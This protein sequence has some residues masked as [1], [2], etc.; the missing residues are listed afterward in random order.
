MLKMAKVF[1]TAAIAAGVTLG[2]G[3]LTRPVVSENPTTKTSFQAQVKQQSIDKVDL[4]FAIDN[5]ASMGD[6]QDLL[7]AAVPILVD[8]LLNPN[9]VATATTGP[10]STC[11]TAADCTSLGA[12]AQC[13]VTGNSGQGQCFL[14]GDNSACSTFPNTKVEFDAVHDMH[15]GIVSSSLGGAVPDTGTCNPTASNDPTHQNDQGHLLNRT[16]NGTTEGTVPNAAPTDNNGGNFLAWLPSANPKNA[17][18]PLPNVTPYTNGDSAPFVAD[19][20]SLVE[21]VQQHG[22]GLEAQLESWYRFLIQ[23]DPYNTIDFTTGG[24]PQ[25]SLD[26]VDATLLKMRHDFLR[27]D[28]L[29]AIIQL[30]DEE[31]SWSDPLWLSSSPSTVSGGYGWTSRDGNFPGGP[32]GGIGAGP[33]GTSDCDQPVNVNTT[34]PSGG[35][36]DPNC[37]SCAFPQSN[38][39]NGQSIGSDANC[40]SCAPGDTNCPVKGWYTPAAPGVAFT[41]A[42]GLNVRYGY[43]YSRQRY[44]LDS[45]HNILRYVDGL[46]STSVP[47]SAHEVHDYQS[48]G[49]TVKNCTNPLFAASLPDGSDTSSGALCALPAGTR[50]PDLVFYALIGGVT[51]SLL[52]DKNGNFKLD[53]SSDDWTAILGADPDHY[54]LD[55]IDPHMIESIAP[56]ANLPPPSTTYNLGS[57]PDN[58]REWNTLSSGAAIDLQYACTFTLPKAKDC[59]APANLGACDCQSSPGTT[60]T[61]PGGPPLCDVATRTSQIKGKAY[62]TIRELRV[63]KAMGAQAVVA[64]LCAE[65]TNPAD[66]ASP[67]YG[68]NPAMQA[69]V[70]RLKAALGGQC[71]P[72]E[73]TQDQT[74]GQVPCLVLAVYSSQTDQTA[75]NACTD[76]GMCNPALPQTCGCAAND[77]DCAA[78]YT[79]ILQRYQESFQASLPDSGTPTPTPVVCVFQQL[80]PEASCTGTNCYTG[81]PGSNCANAPAPNNTGWCYV[82]GAAN[83]GGCAQAIKFGGAGPPAGVTID[84][85]CIE[86]SGTDAGATE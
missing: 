26:G 21:G 36:N 9:C 44:G 48:Y 29:V 85:E 5:S 4:L 56:R 43:Q 32:T 1:V 73:L 28:S 83:T 49:S 46:R 50:T 72:E 60:T 7:A 70:N 31:D 86:A 65:D 64:S 54:V 76:P 14:G 12:N 62:P 67:T 33:R 74:T 19:F 27:P 47:D 66:V 25:A 55:G 17:Q 3:C 23:P 11:A 35:P 59:T 63:A 22:C 84:L 41:A 75:A 6:K 37:V 52:K 18:K 71:L 81:T 79:G 8:R 51:N 30:T 58:G 45:Q 38:K 10:G 80:T 78:T 53:L 61:D 68:Y 42:D 82:Q 57:D 16:Y 40:T 69:I 34:P 20:Q 24:V 77:A 2:A 13:D 15:V 39:P